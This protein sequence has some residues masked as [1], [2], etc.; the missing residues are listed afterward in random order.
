M[1]NFYLMTIICSASNKALIMV[2][3]KWR[4]NSTFITWIA[5]IFSYSLASE[6]YLKI[7][8]QNGGV[9]V[10]AEFNYERQPQVIVS[11]KAEDT[12]EPP[13]TAYA[14]ITVNIQDLND[15]KPELY[16]VRLPSYH[17]CQ[18]HCHCYQQNTS[19]RCM[20]PDYRTRQWKRARITTPMSTINQ[21][22]F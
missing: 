15:E 12:N 1:Y 19:S 22:Y 20:Q 8:P 7:D 4:Y 10:N 18:W 2:K 5:L 14:Q 21:R 16:M 6:S 13:H 17:Y 11:V 9:T 3:C